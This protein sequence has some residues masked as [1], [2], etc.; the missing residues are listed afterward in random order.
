M[1]KTGKAKKL[2]SEKC[3]SETKLIEKLLSL[4]KLTPLAIVDLK[5]KLITSNEVVF[6]NP[7]D[8]LGQL[9]THDG[10][11]KQLPNMY[12]KVWSALRDQK[13]FK[14]QVANSV[15]EVTPICNKKGK[16]VKFLFVDSTSNLG[17]IN[18][19]KEISQELQKFKYAVDFA[20]DHIIMTDSSANIIYA[21]DAVSKIT[22]FSIEEVIGQKAGSKNLWGGLMDPAFYKKMWETISVKK[23]VFSGEIINKRKNGQEYYAKVSIAPVLGKDGEPLYFV[24][25]ERDITAEK[26]LAQSRN[27]FVSLIAQH[28]KNPLAVIGWHSESGIMQAGEK[29]D[30]VQKANFAQINEAVSSLWSMLETLTKVL[31]VKAAPFAFNLETVNPTK[32]AKKVIANIEPKIFKKQIE[33]TEDYDKFNNLHI[34]PNLFTL[35]IETLLNSYL[36]YSPKAAVIKFKIK[37]QSKNLIITLENSMYKLPLVEGG[38]SFSKSSRFRQEKDGELGSLGLALYG[39]NTIVEKIGGDFDFTNSKKCGSKLTIKLPQNWKNLSSA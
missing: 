15:I 31:T 39:L 38:Y 20:S 14:G 28:F 18:F 30:L 1:A 24:G 35:V 19:E 17:N 10:L 34:D 7:S 16:V 25:I 37:K 27:D 13:Y 29:N 5:G 36:D 32:L 23:Q 2:S 12:Q 11:S 22:G 8:G 9:L 33:L 4:S 21:N 3:L 26:E 6:N